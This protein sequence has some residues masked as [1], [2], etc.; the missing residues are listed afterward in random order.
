MEKKLY[1]MKYSISKFIDFFGILK[2]KLRTSSDF[3][4]YL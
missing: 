3:W 4:A 2:K 1:F